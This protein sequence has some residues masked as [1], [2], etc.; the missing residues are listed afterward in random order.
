M[1]IDPDGYPRL[2]VAQRK[3][4]ASLRSARDRR[5]TGLFAAEGLRCVGELLGS[6]VLRQLIFTAEFARDNAPWLAKAEKTSPGVQ[7]LLARRDEMERVSSMQTPQGVLAVFEMPASADGTAR[8]GKIAPGE[9][10]IALDRVQDPGNLGAIVRVADWFGVERL[11]ASADTAD[12]FNPKVVQSTMGALARVRVDYFDSL[13]EVLAGCGAEVCGTF[14]DGES[15]YAAPVAPRDGRGTVL[16]MGN[17]GR[18]ISP[19]VAKTV[20]RRLLIPSYPPGRPTVE[21]LNVATATA[22]CVA[23]LRR[24]QIISERVEIR[25]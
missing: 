14:L 8:C 6:F 5:D 11:W 13:A 12:L 17:E 15:I 3:E 18:G 19:E 23:E 20:T 9:L 4:A 16:V 10:I 24:K 1:S 2:T 25:D 21:S 7:L 22:V